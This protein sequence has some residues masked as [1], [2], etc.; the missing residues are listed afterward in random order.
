MMASLGLAGTRVDTLPASAIY[1]QATPTL[2]V[3]PVR[4]VDPL[5]W[6]SYHYSGVLRPR[7]CSAAAAVIPAS[8]GSSGAENF[9]R[10]RLLAVK[11]IG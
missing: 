3:L 9:R 8:T 7:L 4:N 6:R 1:I 2:T 5:T 10:L 11:Q